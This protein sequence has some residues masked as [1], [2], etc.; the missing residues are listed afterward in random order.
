MSLGGGRREGRHLKTVSETLLTYNRHI[1]SH[2]LQF[3][4]IRIAMGMMF[5]E[6]FFVCVCVY[7]TY[8]CLLFWVTEHV[9]SSFLFEHKGNVKMSVFESR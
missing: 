6:G 9:M 7:E 5:A 1:H 4:L 2:T 8:I 3:A